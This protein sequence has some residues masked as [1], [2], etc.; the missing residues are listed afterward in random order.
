MIIRNPGG[1][2]T[3][4]PPAAAASSRLSRRRPFK[5]VDKPAGIPLNRNNLLKRHEA[6]TVVLTIFF[7]L[8]LNNIA[9]GRARIYAG[10]GRAD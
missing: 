8:F 3:Y 10:L 4:Y 1:G 5:G 2:P 9:I 6:Q 7:V